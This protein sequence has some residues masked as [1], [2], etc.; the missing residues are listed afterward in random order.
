[1]YKEWLAVRVIS[2]PNLLCYGASIYNGQLQGPVTITRIAERL[3]VEV[4][5]PVFTTN[6]CRGWDLNTQP[7]ACMVSFSSA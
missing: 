4:S 3:A 1:M 5:L 7:S 6:V 2:V